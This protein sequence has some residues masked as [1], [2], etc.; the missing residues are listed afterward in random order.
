V[1]STAAPGVY[2]GA[3]LARATS[4]QVV[5][6][7]VFA[8]VGLHDPD[9]AAG[10]APGAQARIA[11]DRDI[12]AKGDTI[13]P[14]VVGAANGATGDWQVFPVDLAAGLATARFSIVDTAAGDE[15]Y[16]LYLYD[17]SLD[18]VASSHPFAADGTTDVG[19][20]DQRRRTFDPIRGAQ[21]R[22]VVL[23]DRHQRV[24]GHGS[25]WHYRVD[26]Q[27]AVR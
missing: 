23:D 27:Q 1:P 22:G 6:I 5:R 16:D 21:L 10:N 4:G 13:W 14:S 12:F 15:T 11:S 17:A 25:R 3:V 19:A 2:T 9:P 24:D 20:N 7:P 26:V 18:L 8:S